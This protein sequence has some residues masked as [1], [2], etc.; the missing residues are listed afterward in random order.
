ML[1]TRLYEAFASIWENLPSEESEPI[2]T[3]AT[4]NAIDMLPEEQV[5]Y[6][7]N[8]SLT[9]PPC[10]EGVLWSVMEQPIE[11]SAEQIAAFTDI[12]E[13]SNRPVQPLHER[14]LHIDET[15]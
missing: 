1:S 7:Y 12:F 2:A 13:I 6:R 11:M 14:V 10:S 15:R 8:G 9:T 3:D 5:I 4:A